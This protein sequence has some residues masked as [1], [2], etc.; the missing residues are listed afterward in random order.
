M[1][2]PQKEG[3]PYFEWD[4]ELDIAHKQI[5]AEYGFK[6]LGIV[7][8]IYSLIYKGHGYY[9]EWNSESL[10]LFMLENGV[11]GDKQ[12]NLIQNVVSA[13]IKRD[14]FS[15]QLYQK[16][17]ILTSEKIQENYFRATA[18]RKLSEV[19]KEYLLLS[20]ANKEVSVCNNSKIV[21]NNSK[22]VCNNSTDKIREDKKIISK[23]ISDPNDTVKRIFDA[24]NSLKDLGIPPIIKIEKKST[25]Y[26]ALSARLKEYSEEDVLTAIERIKNSDFLQGQNDRNWIIK[27]D[28]F[29]KPNNFIKVL[30]GNYDNK[31][32]QSLSG[33]QP[34]WQP[35][36]KN[37]NEWQ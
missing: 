26:K 20:D 8:M 34:T 4:T 22:I 24:W 36:I 19:K 17:G 14:I 25:R 35:E 31:K 6:G 7:V 9:V 23:D 13:C 12:R 30:E 37:G 5:L 1:S 18:R 3:I 27:F 2:R 21:C 16:Y 11:S 28:W 10:L 29:L 15:Q 33:W 32:N